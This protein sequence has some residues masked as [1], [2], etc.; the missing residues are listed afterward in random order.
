M[1]ELREDYIEPVLSALV[2][3]WFWE[4]TAVFLLLALVETDLA[5]RAWLDSISPPVNEVLPSGDW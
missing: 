4:L 2:P 1:G 3:T 5:T